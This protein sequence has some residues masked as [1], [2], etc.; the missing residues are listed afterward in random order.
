VISLPA[1]Q[2]QGNPVPALRKRDRLIRLTRW[3]HPNIFR[4][5]AVL[6]LL[7]I[8]TLPLGVIVKQLV[9]EIDEQIEFAQ[10]ELRG[11]SY[12]KK[13]VYFM[14][15]VQEHQD[16]A[17]RSVDRSG[18]NS[19][20][21][22]S[23]RDNLD[24]KRIEIEAQI[25]QINLE[26]ERSG[27][28]LKTTEE[29]K[30]LLRD[31]QLIVKAMDHKKLTRRELYTLHDSVIQEIQDQILNVGNLSNLILDPDRQTYHLIDSITNH[32][33]AAI[34]KVGRASN[35]YQDLITGQL[36]PRETPVEVQSELTFLKS[37]L[38]EANQ[39]LN[40][41][42][43]VIWKE[44]QTLELPNYRFLK[45]SQQLI[46]FSNLLLKPSNQSPSIPTIQAQREDALNAH[47]ALYDELIPIAQ[48]LLQNRITGKSNQKYQAIAFTS[49]ALLAIVSV[50]ITLAQTWQQRFQ[51]EQ[52]LKLQYKTTQIAAEAVELETALAAIL[53]AI[54]RNQN[55]S[56][57]EL[58][59]VEPEAE[60][61]DP[62]GSGPRLKLQ[63][64]WADPDLMQSHGPAL[65]DWQQV[66]WRLRV[67]PNVGM[68]GR[69]LQHGDLQW[70]DLRGNI[71]SLWGRTTA[72]RSLSLQ[73]G[74]GV[75]ILQ[76]GRVMGVL[77]LFSQTRHPQ[78]DDTEAVL[79]TLGC[80]LGE[81]IHRL[82]TAQE[83]VQAKNEA[84]AAS[85]S[86][87]QFLANMSHEL[88][89]PLNAIIGYSELLQE[90][91]KE[92]GLSNIVSDLDKVQNA[93]RHLLGLINDILD[94]SKIEAGRMNLYLEHFEVR[95]LMTLIVPTI[96][97]LIQA[98]QN[99]LEIN[100]SSEVSNMYADV[101]KVRQSLLNLLSNAAKFT[102]QG[103]ITLTIRLIPW[104]RASSKLGVEFQVKDTGIGI[105]TE[106][107]GKLFQIFSQADESS[108]REYGGTGLGLAISQQFCHLM[109]GTISVESQMGQGSTFTMHLPLTVQP[110][111]PA[112]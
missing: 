39:H 92:E 13:L 84:E 57:G 19:A 11:I 12:N 67:Q 41:N 87:S 83:L 22:P 109:G 108:T 28:V 34:I 9:M 65:A 37:S 107:L 40:Y 77:A 48:T 110:L 23:L 51:A 112:P 81:F 38:Q 73:S 82:H 98:N 36:D 104:H 1:P 59:L 79:S 35:L 44:N 74:V 85:R 111:P 100:V 96:E 106:D 63:Q 18:S 93:G 21:N 45:A 97:P 3:I 25:Q 29:W 105:A 89:T 43:Q 20:I 14:K 52:R 99:H 78:T 46:Q 64:F 42:R 88:R 95:S 16:L 47:F 62:G 50:Y 61:S 68:L 102:H 49:L 53:K 72:A 24:E 66:S 26:D 101:M 8:F 2:P 7:G 27:K 69:V 5:I 31:W 70:V 75:A 60:N 58:W 10:Q 86:K 6:G 54:C 91:A 55:W 33:P 30:Q 90:D 103:K 94:L 4:Q 76:G 56:L 71:S 80:H 32:I 17:H 15:L